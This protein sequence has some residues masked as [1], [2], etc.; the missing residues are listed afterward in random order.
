M[1]TDKRT[2]IGVVGGMGPFAGLDLVKK[3]FDLTDA[4]SDQDHLPVSLLSMPHA[5]T[6]RSAFLH[7]Q[8]KANPG[9]AISEV[10]QSLC[11]Q[12]A[13]I[14]GMPC[15][16]AHT[17]PIFNEIKKRIPSDVTII[18]MIKKVTEHILSHHSTAKTIGILC[19]SGTAKTNVYPHF[20]E[21]RGLNGIH[22]DEEI[23]SSVVDEAIYN[24][25][26]GIKAQSNPVTE[27]AKEGLGQA[28]EQLIDSG[29]KV[30]I[31]GCTEIPLAITDNE[32]NGI[33]LIDA[34][35]VLAKEL[36]LAS[37]PTSLR[38]D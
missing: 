9:V 29:A 30:I 37:S 23:Q 35:T 26:Y 20:L 12:G 1:N 8:T 17:E 27:K 19:T 16:T 31:L 14:I 6:D 38:N 22:V 5:I 15:N 7:G 21:K 24:E 10:I 36:I 25:S 18:H 3:I 4:T 2:M 32:Y 34:T 11:E 13:T 28:I 33:P